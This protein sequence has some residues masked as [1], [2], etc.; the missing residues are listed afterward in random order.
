MARLD[1]YIRLIEQALSQT[2]AKRGIPSPE[3]VEAIA[4]AKISLVEHSLQLCFRLKQEVGS[5]ALMEGTGFEQLDFITMC[6]FA[7]GDSRILQSK[8]CRDAVRAKSAPAGRS[9]VESELLGKLKSSQGQDW[10]LT[11]QMADAVCERTID[12]W[13]ADKDARL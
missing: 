6:K 13:V 10:A 5:F 1:K 11:F 3:L 4:V 2:L 9:R 12:Q 8:L 7:E